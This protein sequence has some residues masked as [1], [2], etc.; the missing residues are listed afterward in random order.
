MKKINVLC[1]FGT[2]P[3][4]I[5]MA[6][7]IKALGNNNQICTKVCVTGQHREMLDQVLDCFNI[8]PDFDLDIMHKQQNLTDITIK[9]L[10]GLK[11]ILEQYKPDYVLVHGDTTTAF[12]ASLVS[13]YYKIKIAHVEAGLR[14]GNLE[15]PWPEEANRKLISCITSLHFAPTELSKQNLL[16]E[17]LN[18]KNIFVTG[19]TVIDSL[20]YVRNRFEL[21]ITFRNETSKKFSYLNFSKKIILVTAHRRENL[22]LGFSNICDAI[23]IIANI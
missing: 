16:N 3:E 20:L 23:K 1:V 18:I 13:F 17:N 11:S 22:G 21:D 15:S 5:K 12:A 6:P 4:A 2:R 10:E 19:N 9:V 8:V 7:V 14:T